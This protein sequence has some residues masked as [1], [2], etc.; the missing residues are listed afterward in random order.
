MT[1]HDDIR[2]LLGRL[3]GKMDLLLIKGSDHDKRI[4]VLEAWKNRISGI[5]AFSGFLITMALAGL[6]YVLPK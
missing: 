1:E 6:A 2:L 3:D 4:S 5:L